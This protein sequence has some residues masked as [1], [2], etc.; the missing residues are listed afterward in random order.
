MFFYAII[1]V[2]PAALTGIFFAAGFTHKNRIAAD[3]IDILPADADSFSFAADAEIFRSAVNNERHHPAAAF[4]NLDIA[5]KAEPAAVCLVDY[6][7]AAQLGYTTVHPNLPLCI[8]MLLYNMRI[9][10]KPLQAKI[11]R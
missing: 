11:L 2:N 10:M 9:R 4:I 8:I 3:N 1:S 5:H 7:L 6:L